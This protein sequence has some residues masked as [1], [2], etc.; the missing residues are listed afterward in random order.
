MSLPGNNFDVRQRSRSQN[1]AKWKSLSQG[2]RMP[3]INA[4]LLIL[5]KI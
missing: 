4:L 2:S 3:I 5:Q 1:G